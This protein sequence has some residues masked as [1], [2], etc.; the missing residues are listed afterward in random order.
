[1]RVRS[2]GILITYSVHVTANA[3]IGTLAVL[4]LR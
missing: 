4:I 2:G 3:V 1:M